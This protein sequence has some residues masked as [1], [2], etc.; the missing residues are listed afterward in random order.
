MASEPMSAFAR[1]CTDV[2]VAGTHQHSMLGKRS[3]LV[4]NQVSLKTDATA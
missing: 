4:E 3:R 2:P 1:I